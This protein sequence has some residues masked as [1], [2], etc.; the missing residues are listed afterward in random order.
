M[1]IIVIRIIMIII[2]IIIIASKHGVPR[3][4]HVGRRGSF[5]SGARSYSVL[6]YNI[7]CYAYYSLVDYDTV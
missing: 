2:I 1:I 5:G 7:V 4:W 3:R 6:Y